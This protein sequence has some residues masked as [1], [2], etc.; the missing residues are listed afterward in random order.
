MLFVRFFV[1]LLILYCNRGAD[2][3]QTEQIGPAGE[4][5]SRGVVSG[6]GVCGR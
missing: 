6:L 3:L 4:R 2:I 5:S 1:R